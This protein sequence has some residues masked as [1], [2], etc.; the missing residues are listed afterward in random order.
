MSE[1]CNGSH[2]GFRVQ[3][4]KG[5]AGS[6]PASDTMEEIERLRE[7]NKLLRR[8]LTGAWVDYNGIPYQLA[9]EF[10]DEMEI[11][12]VQVNRQDV[13]MFYKM[14]EKDVQAVVD[15]VGTGWYDHIG[16]A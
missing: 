13:G 10:I 7:E 4:S 9:D 15:K 5:G 6:T 3:S 14:R 12:V 16:I 1:W 11:G 2:A 8:V